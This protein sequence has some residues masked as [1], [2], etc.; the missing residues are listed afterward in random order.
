MHMVGG[1]VD[2]YLCGEKEFYRNER[3]VSGARVLDIHIFM[4]SK[5]W[6]QSPGLS[7]KAGPSSPFLQ[8]SSWLLHVLVGLQVA[9]TVT[10]AW[11][12]FKARLA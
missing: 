6:E 11:T 1:N 4:K 3:K 10:E 7:G 5:K 8:V 12:L 2:F 9:E